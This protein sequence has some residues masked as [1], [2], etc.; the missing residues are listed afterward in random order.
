MKRLLAIMVVI[1]G[2]VIPLGSIAQEVGGGDLIF[3]PKNAFP[4]AFSHKK[5]EVK[6]LKCSG[7]HYHTFQME[8][9][10]A[11]KMDMTKMTKGAFCGRCHN[12]E[13][14]F[15]VKDQKSCSLCHHKP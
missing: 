7:C 15:D 1:I 3:S 10:A 4:V 6:G 2:I 9:G 5:H 14:A 11:Y 13:I 8:K 12:G